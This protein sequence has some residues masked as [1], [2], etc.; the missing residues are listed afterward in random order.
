[1][2]RAQAAKT[3]ATHSRNRLRDGGD[4]RTIGGD[5]IKV[6]WYTGEEDFSLHGIAKFDGM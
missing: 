2:P 3:F 1:M 4:W 6:V 5:P